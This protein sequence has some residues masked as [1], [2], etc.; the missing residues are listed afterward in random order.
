MLATKVSAKLAQMRL[1]HRQSS[2]NS[3]IVAC[4]ALVLVTYVVR[5]SLSVMSVSM[6]AELG[7]TKEAEGSVLSAFF[8]GCILRQEYFASRPSLFHLTPPLSSAC[9]TCVP[10]SGTSARTSAA[11]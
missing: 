3:I 8:Y 6:A 2:N 10:I 9:Y 4:G 11:D 5:A 1:G 7:W